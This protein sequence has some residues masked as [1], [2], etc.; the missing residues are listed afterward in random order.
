MN[1]QCVSEFVA[2]GRGED[3]AGSQAGVHLGPIEVHPPMSG[4]GGRWHVLGLGPVDEEVGHSLGLDGGAG[5]I[6]DCVR[7]QRNGPF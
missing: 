6:V 1:L 5:M 3:D 2:L 4:V 7:S